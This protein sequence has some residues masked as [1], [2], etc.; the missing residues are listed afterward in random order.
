M[1]AAPAAA[2]TDRSAD[3]SGNVAAVNIDDRTSWSFS[4]AVTFRFTHVLGFEVEATAAPDLHT[5]F[6]GVTIQ[7]TLPPVFTSSLSGYEVVQS[8]PAPRFENAG[9]RLI[10]LSNNVRV[11]IPTTAARLE[12]YFVAGGGIAST[13]RTADVVYT[14]GTIIAPVPLGVPLPPVQTRTIRQPVTQSTTDLAL[15][16]G[17][18]I[19]VR[20]AG[21]M[22]VEGDLRLIRLLGSSDR[23]VGRFGVGVR[24]RF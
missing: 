16:L 1:L 13:R 11:A 19:S 7:T 23:N 24:Y 18:G 12:P 9:G 5:N 3:V 17:G 2:Q 14:T 4:G 10:L 8:F 22:A 21:P 20:V 6:P 15:T